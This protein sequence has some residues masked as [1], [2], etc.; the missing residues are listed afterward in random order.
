MKKTY[1]FCQSCGMP[2]KQDP[3][4]GGVNAD[5]TINH[6]YCSYCYEDGDY[7]F[8]GTAAE[9]QEFCQNK[10]REMGMNRFSAWLFTRGIPR[11]ERWNAVS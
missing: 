11:L 4:G 7:T 6:K 1:K 2:M 3:K 10:M 9:M 8:N 5:G